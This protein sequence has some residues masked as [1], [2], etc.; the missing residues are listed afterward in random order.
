MCRQ[1]HEEIPRQGIRYVAKRARRAP[2]R[3]QNNVT[4]SKDISAKVRKDSTIS[5]P[6]AG[7]IVIEGPDNLRGHSMLLSI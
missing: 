4:I 1:Q 7:T 2:I 5:Q 3:T 6:E